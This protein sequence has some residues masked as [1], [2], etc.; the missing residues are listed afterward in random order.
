MAKFQT[1]ICKSILIKCNTHRCTLGDMKGTVLVG[2]LFNDLGDILGVSTILAEHCYAGDNAVLQGQDG[3]FRHNKVLFVRCQ[4]ILTLL[5]SSGQGLLAGFLGSNAELVLN[6]TVPQIDFQAAFRHRLI[7]A[8]FVLI[9][10]LAVLVAKIDDSLTQ[11]GIV[12]GV[13]LYGKVLAFAFLDDGILQALNGHSGVNTACNGIV[14]VRCAQLHIIPH[15]SCGQLLVTGIFRRNAEFIIFVVTVTQ[16]D[17]QAAFRHGLIRTVFVLIFDLAVLIA[18]G[19]DTGTGAARM[20]KGHGKL[21]R[22]FCFD[23]TLQTVD[24]HADFLGKAAIFPLAILGLFVA[25]QIARIRT[26]QVQ[27][28]LIICFCSFGQL[29]AITGVGT[30]NRHLTGVVLG[31][32]NLSISIKI[33]IADGIIKICI[34]QLNAAGR[35][36]AVIVFFINVILCPLESAAIYNGFALITGAKCRA[37]RTTGNLNGTRVKNQLTVFNNNCITRTSYALEGG[38]SVNRQRFGTRIMKPQQP[39]TNKRAS[40]NFYSASFVSVVAAKTRDGIIGGY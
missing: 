32:I 8:G 6:L 19:Q 39:A 3:H 15:H 18:K 28:L 14:L 23:L 10:D 34:L 4:L 31:H 26:R 30:L 36:S 22:V 11:L 12:L 21:C 27:I 7:R 17:F 38:V 33:N 2:I 16:T 29:T 35:H 20:G 1:A 24:G 40:V 13:N 37:L 25:H 5:D 9:L